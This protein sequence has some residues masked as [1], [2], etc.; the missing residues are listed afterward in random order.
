MSFLTT[1]FEGIRGNPCAFHIYNNTSDGWLKQRTVG[2]LCKHSLINMLPVTIE[3]KGELLAVSCA[4]CHIIRLHDIATSET[5]VAFNDND[6]KALGHMC[7]G[8]T[9]SLY[10]AYKR[11][12]QDY[13]ILELGCSTTKFRAM[14]TYKTGISMRQEPPHISYI[15]SC[16]LIVT[17]S[18]RPSKMI[19]AIACTDDEKQ[20]KSISC[21][22][23]DDDDADKASDDNPSDQ[24]ATWQHWYAYHTELRDCG[25][26]DGDLSP[27]SLHFSAHNDRLIAGDMLHNRLMV[28]DPVDGTHLQTIALPT[29]GWVEEIC[30]YD[31]KWYRISPENHPSFLNRV[32]CGGGSS[33]Q[34]Q[35]K[36]T[37]APS[38]NVKQPDTSNSIAVWLD[39]PYSA[40]QKQ[41][42]S[43]F[44]IK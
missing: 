32:L 16:Q 30:P 28:M 2:A 38:S 20:R 7:H 21:S 35:A 8:E 4:E 11:P 24:I 1:S 42:V 13:K 25:D 6:D 34:T 26:D 12:P 39:N 19:R 43:F 10:V 44:T 3:H 31:L 36:N 23:T 14:K 27:S 29:P 41:T 40:T 37:E 33:S 15:P 9:G 18:N 5:T 22:G 17:C